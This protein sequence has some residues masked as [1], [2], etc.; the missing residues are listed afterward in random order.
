VD[1]ATGEVTL[2]RYVVAQD[3]G[4]V[5]NPRYCEGQVTGG[6][7]QGIGQAMFEEIIHRG[8]YVMNPNFTDYKLPTL[9]DVPHIE[10]ILVEVPSDSGPYG[11]K[12]VGE[13]AIIGPPAA[14]ANAV[15]DA[16]GHPIQRLPITAERVWQSLRSPR[17]AS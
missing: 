8:G 7:V 6:A 13:Q 10:T 16:T 15:R 1:G 3:V 11:A 12:G 2:D 17:T 5:V 14:I 4:R 9:R